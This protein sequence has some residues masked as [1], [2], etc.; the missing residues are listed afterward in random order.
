MTERKCYVPSESF[1]FFSFLVCVIHKVDRLSGGPYDLGLLMFLTLW[2]ALPLCVGG[3]HDLL[4]IHRWDA[5]PMI[6]LCSTKLRLL[7]DLL[8]WKKQAALKREAEA[9]CPVATR[10]YILPTA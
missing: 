2:G 7:A 4:L 10:K 9:L 5:M 6:M 8:P 3:T 1:F